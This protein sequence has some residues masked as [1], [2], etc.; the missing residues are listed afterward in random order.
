MLGKENIECQLLITF[1]FMKVMIHKIVALLMAIFMLV[2]TVSWTVE[3]HF[4]LGSLVDIAFFHEAE[5]CGMEMPLLNEGV[6]LDKDSNNCCSDEIVSVQGQ[7][8]LSISQYDLSFGQPYFL[9]ALT[10]YY[11]NLFQSREQH[12]VPHA[13]YPPPILV[14]DIQILDQVFLI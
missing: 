3:K 12:F 14:R 1:A 4:C 2:S 10:C 11:I 9:A 5:T 8:E 6:V 7:D 13:D